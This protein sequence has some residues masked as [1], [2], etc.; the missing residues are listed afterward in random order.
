MGLISEEK[1]RIGRKGFR[2]AEHS[3]AERRVG[4]CQQAM[5]A[6]FVLNQT[7]VTDATPQG[8]RVA[9]SLTRTLRL[10]GSLVAVV[11][12][13]KPDYGVELYGEG[14]ASMCLILTQEELTHLH[15]AFAAKTRMQVEAF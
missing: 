11:G 8:R 3:K 2:Q 14:E 15:M 5:R 13:G 1:R 4:H 6:L 12:E 9:T 7:T 10:D